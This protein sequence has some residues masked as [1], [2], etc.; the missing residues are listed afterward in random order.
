M[1]VHEMDFISLTLSFL[2]TLVSG[3]CFIFFNKYSVSYGFQIQSSNSSNTGLLWSCQIPC[4]FRWCRCF[5]LYRTF[6]FFGKDLVIG[7]SFLVFFSMFLLYCF[8][9]FNFSYFGYFASVV[10]LQESDSQKEIWKSYRRRSLKKVLFWY[11]VFA[12]TCSTVLIFLSIMQSA[13]VWSCSFTLCY[14]FVF[15]V[16]KKL[17]FYSISSS[18][19]FPRLWSA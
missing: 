2:L 12:E 4:P 10:V 17:I 13:V 3:L 8:E 7:W 1:G 16:T 11:S 15:F 14:Y 19:T 18:V 6:P 9:Y 5:M